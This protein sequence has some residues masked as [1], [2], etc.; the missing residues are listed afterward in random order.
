MSKPVNFDR[1]ARAELDAAIGWYDDEREGLG[2]ELL[3]DVLETALLVG[4]APDARP[5]ARDAGP[6]PAGAPVVREA[7]LRR[8]PYRL[9]YFELAE[10]VIVLAVAHKRQ[11][12]GYWRGRLG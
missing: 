11:R 3:G 8:F 5:E 9:V 1:D 2:D 10:L 12:P 6:L 7:L 4:E